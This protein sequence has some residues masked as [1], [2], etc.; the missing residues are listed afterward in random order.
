MYVRISIRI[1]AYVGIHIRVYAYKNAYIYTLAYTRL[2]ISMYELAY[3]LSVASDFGMCSKKF[4]T[5]AS[6]F[7]RNFLETFY[8]LYRHTR[9]INSTRP[10]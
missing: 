5:G 8:S 6:Y 1:C 3:C 10:F 2:F 7:S 4:N 9:K